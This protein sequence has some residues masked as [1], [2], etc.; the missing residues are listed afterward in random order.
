MNNFVLTIDTPLHDDDLD[1]LTQDLVAVLGELD[2]VTARRVKREGHSEGGKSGVEEF[3]LNQ[4]AVAFV[5]NVTSQAAQPYLER[6]A[7]AIWDWTQKQSVRLGQEM[8]VSL[9]SAVIS[10]TM[11]WVMVAQLIDTIRLQKGQ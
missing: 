8:K 10:S 3:I 5:V 1:S 4:I 9:G 11:T 2:E 6:W 7:K